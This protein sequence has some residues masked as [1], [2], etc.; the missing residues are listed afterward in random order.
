MIDEEMKFIDIAPIRDYAEKINCPFIAIIG[1]KGTGKTYGCIDRAIIDFY[2]SNEKYP[3]F[4]VRRYDK[5]FTK[6]ICGN[7]LNIHSQ[8]IINCSK[9]R[10]NTAE[11]SGKVY[12]VMHKTADDKGIDKRV[13][14]K[15]IAYCRS[16]NNVETETGDD[17]GEIS[18]GIYDEFLSRDGE[19]K[20]EF[21]K[22]NILHSNMLRNRVNKFVPLYLLGN[23]VSRDSKTAEQFGIKL[24]DLKRGLNVYRNKSGIPRIVL[25]YT[26]ET[27]A[28][29]EAA[30]MYYDRF[31]NDHINMISHGD[32]VLGTYKIAPQNML[33]KTGYTW[34]L[35]NNGFAV[36]VTLYINGLTPVIVV[37]RPSKNFNIGVSPIIGKRNILTMPKQI[38]QCVL[39]GAMYAET[40]EIGEDFRDI[41]KHIN[42]GQQIVNYIG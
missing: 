14:K 38:T 19:L 16:M 10:H 30:S 39:N 41:C 20:D 15:I 27:V 28:N 33:Y 18:C 35:Y 37:K 4:Y 31:E 25:Y 21:L 1:G 40:S 9:G 42:G 29:S 3:F 6:S 11:L 23:T 12:E 17:K 36:N 5:T 26:P 22:L 7:L 8:T 2:K 34:K 32:W 24:R 13:N